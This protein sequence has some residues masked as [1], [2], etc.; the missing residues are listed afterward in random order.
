[1]L[2]G[3]ELLIIML[4]KS[5]KLALG[6]K[7]LSLKTILPASI[8][9]DLRLIG[10]IDLL[11]VK[12]KVHIYVIDNSPT[13]H[14]ILDEY[15][16]IISDYKGSTKKPTRSIVKWVKFFRKKDPRL[17]IRMWKELGEAGILR[18]KGKKHVLLKPEIK[19]QLEK[20]ISLISMRKK[21]PDEF[22]RA[23]CGF[24]KRFYG[25]R[26]FEGKRDK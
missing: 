19:T 4:R 5:G 14:T 10:K 8:L 17:E 20:D 13:R 25:W 26:H 1:M 23:L 3:E 12:K 2:L 16:Q 22:M 11:Q 6:G 7:G 15:L 21:E 24:V 18:N 9:K